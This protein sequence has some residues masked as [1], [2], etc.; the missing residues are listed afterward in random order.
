[1]KNIFN[2]IIKFR[3]LLAL[4]I[5]ILGV[6]SDFNFSSIPAWEQYVP[7]IN[8]ATSK[9]LGQTRYIRTDEWVVQTPMYMA[10]VMDKDH[11]PVYNKNI[12]LSGQNMILNYNAPT[13]DITVLSKPFNWGFLLLGKGYGLS[14]Y[15]FSKLLLYLLLSYEMCFI[16]TKGNKGISVLGSLW[17]TFSP[18]V[19]WW[20]M[21]HI[22][23]L[24]LYFEAIIVTYYY[25]LKNSNNT[26]RRILLAFAFALSCIGFALVLYP[27]VQVPLFYLGIIFMIV[28]FIDLKKDL[29]LEKKDVLIIILSFAFIFFNLIH[30][31]LISKDSIKI[32]LNTTYPGKRVSVG[33]NLSFFALNTFL[34]NVLLPFKNSTYL[35]N[36]EVS[37][38]YNFL[39]PLIFCI[40]VLIKKKVKDLKLGIALIIFI[41]FQA[42]YMLWGIPVFLSKITLFSYVTEQRLLAIYSLTSL[43][44]SI[45]ALNLLYKKRYFN[46]IFCAVI[47]L[48]TTII[49]YFS[50]FYSPFK[51]YVSP[52]YYYIILLIFFVLSFLLLYGKK[53]YFI[54]LMAILVL[55]S[56]ITVN[57]LTKGVN[58]IYNNNLSKNIVSISKKSPNANW[59]S[60]DDTNGTMGAFIY[61]NGAK[62]LNGVN[63]YPDLAEW[64]LLDK[65]GSQNNIYN[66]Y[67]HFSFSLTDKKTYFTLVAPDSTHVFIN[68]KDIKK[69]KIKFILSKNNL[70]SYSDSSIKFSKIYS[71]KVNKYSIYKLIY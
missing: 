57:P 50:I 69:L 59:I 20:F 48:I 64:K 11:F 29:I 40:P 45:W 25:F 28:L 6:A 24:V 43:Y 17:I 54:G 42:F 38:F 14:W 18:A 10:Q 32:L 12:G 60:I 39:I 7:Q 8:N 70:D 19:Q 27:A 4:L 9:I 35:N 2:T 51:T 41:L 67:S 62:C 53:N 55:I 46:F 5:L 58:S 26:L 49:Y 1:M 36:C 31:Y 61:A 68:T 65:T 47:S 52:K 37:S 34:I 13:R 66:R 22:G 21:Q 44:L 71:D 23:D 30:F 56:G 63:F 3:Y 15:W 16:I 33:G